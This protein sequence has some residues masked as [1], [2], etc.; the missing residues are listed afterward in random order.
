MKTIFACVLGA[1]LA[2][3]GCG[4]EHPQSGGPRR[5]N[6]PPYDPGF[7]PPCVA[8]AGTPVAAGVTDPFILLA[9]AARSD[10]GF[11]PP[12][13]PTR[14]TV[15][16]PLLYEGRWSVKWAVETP[17]EVVVGIVGP[18]GCGGN[19]M[20]ASPGKPAVVLP[21]SPKPARLFFCPREHCGS[22]PRP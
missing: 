18:S 9:M 12:P 6:E 7:M 2:G 15:D 17:T 5:I 19:M 22:L 21:A 14:R 13:D 8:P 11:T 3:G 1:A 20:S 4:D 10:G 16:L